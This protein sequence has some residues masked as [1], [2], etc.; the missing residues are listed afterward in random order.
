MK[1]AIAL[2]GGGPAVGLSLGAL[3]RLEKESDIRFDVWST[4]CIGGWVAALYNQAPP[5]QGSETAMNFFRSVFQPDEV[6]ARYPVANVFTP[7]MDD[8]VQYMTSFLFNPKSYQHLI[9]PH[10]IM[11][12]FS[13]VGQ[14][15]MSPGE[16]T[17]HGINDLVFNHVMPAHPLTRFLTSM[18]YL[19]PIHGLSR[20]YDA[21]HLTD[22]RLE[23][24]CN[25]ADGRLPIISAQ[26]L[27]A[28]SALPFLEDT[29]EID[30]KTYCEGA[31]VDTVGLSDL[32][33]NHPDLDEVWISRILDTGQ[34][35]E[36]QNLTE[37]LSNLIMLF[38]A[39]MSEDQVELF[40]MRLAEEGRRVRVVE[41]P[42]SVDIDHSWTHGNLERA[43]VAGYEAAGR[44]IAEYRSRRAEEQVAPAARIEIPQSPMLPPVWHGHGGFEGHQQFVAAPDK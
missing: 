2:S 39:K 9:I 20:L 4:A 42:V 21:Y 44:A 41:I 3:Q 6:Y 33:T 14:F 34:I 43:T 8:I 16:W 29:V 24:F 26:S 18:I 10:K 23:L 12:M 32:L 15:M 1:R 19:S 22:Q 7:N 38:A 5:G 35:H 11:D 27:C 31:L 13:R 40:K 17:P 37:A 30:G 36:P 28:C 25:K